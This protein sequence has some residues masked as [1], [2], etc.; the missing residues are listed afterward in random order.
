MLDVERR[1]H[2]ESGVEQF[3]D[4]AA[5]GAAFGALVCA[6][7]STRSVWGA[8]ERRVNVNSSSPARDSRFFFAAGLRG[9]RA[10]WRFRRVVGLD[11]A[12]DES[13][14]SALTRRAPAAWQKSSHAGSGAEEDL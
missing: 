11:E 2:V 13:T 1:P 6:S 4:P 5:L 10:E 14:P 3:L 9:L 8:L 12:D 7:S